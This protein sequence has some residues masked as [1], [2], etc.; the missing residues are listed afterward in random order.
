MLQDGRRGTVGSQDALVRCTAGSLS[1]QEPGGEQKLLSEVPL[2]RTATTFTSQETMLSGMLIEGTGGDAPRPLVV[3]VHGSERTSPRDSVYPLLL[4]AHGLDVFIYDKRGT[5]LSDG[6]YTQ[7]FELLAE[8]AAAAL[9]EARRLTAGRHARIGFY[10]GSQG[11][12]IAPLAATRAPADF[13]AVGFGLVASPIE[14]DQDQVLTE[15][16]ERGYDDR[17]LARA[18]EVTKATAAVMASHFSSGF[19]E[20]AAVKR[21]YAAEPWFNAI[22]GEFTGELL[23][24]SEADLRRL[25][26]ARFD[27]LELIWDYDSRPVIRSLK[28]PLLWV[29]AEADREAPPASTL[30][31]LQELQ[32]QGANITVYSFPETDH[33]MWEF[34][35]GRDAQRTYTRVT[36]GYF[37]LL[38]DWIR[39]TAD[40]PYGRGHLRIGTAHQTMPPSGK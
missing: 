29:V 8:D 3:M 23:R 26:R 2:K 24:T 34:E 25:G 13:V 19:E 21:R 20:L 33:G 38:A 37:R 36:D 32:A 22:E 31:R 6:H 28:V 9:A 39:G 5:G 1:L 11:G 15:L 16:R 10:G 14:E 12:W 4:V 7:N 30:S 27:N 18:H 40:G 35:E 17:V